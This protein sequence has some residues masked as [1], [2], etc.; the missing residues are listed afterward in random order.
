MMSKRGTYTQKGRNDFGPKD[1]APG[2]SVQVADTPFGFEKA[3]RIFNKKVQDSG[4]LRELKER[5]CY[6]KPS[7]IRKRAKAVA[8]KRWLRIQEEKNLPRGKT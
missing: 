5:E 3:M 8:R 4:L 2:L 6:E 1:I 7:V